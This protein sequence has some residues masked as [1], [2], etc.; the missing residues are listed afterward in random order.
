VPG[1]AEAAAR[2]LRS[3]GI[4]AVLR[5]QG[6]VDGDEVRIGDVI[7]EFTEEMSSE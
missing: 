1:A 7:F 5:S 6:A 2:R 3:A 4:D